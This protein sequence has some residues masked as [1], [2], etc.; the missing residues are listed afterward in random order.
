MI[1]LELDNWIQQQLLPY[2]KVNKCVPIHTTFGSYVKGILN[3][4]IYLGS[5]VSLLS[6]EFVLLFRRVKTNF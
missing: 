6:N 4:N 3:F 1:Y 2:S 5:K